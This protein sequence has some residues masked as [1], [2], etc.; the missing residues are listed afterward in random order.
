MQQLQ[1]LSIPSIQ[2]QIGN[3]TEYLFFSLRKLTE[4]LSLVVKIR[5]LVQLQCGLTTSPSEEFNSTWMF[6]LLQI[7]ASP[8]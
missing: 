1:H 4:Q 5:S 6:V 7:K 3:T 2:V 8:D